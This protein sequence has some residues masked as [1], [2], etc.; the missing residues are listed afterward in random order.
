M[1]RS[2]DSGGREF[3]CEEDVEEFRS[4]KQH[5]RFDVW[6]GQDEWH[7]TIQV[8]VRL[9]KD[10]NVFLSTQKEHVSTLR[11]ATVT[12]EEFYELIRSIIDKKNKE[13]HS[14]TGN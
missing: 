9:E 14:E 12:M 3:G 7:P 2:F 10:G 5:R 6:K 11:I 13:R 4:I 1:S 8:Q